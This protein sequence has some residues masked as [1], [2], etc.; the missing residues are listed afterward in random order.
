MKKNIEDL[1]NPL[2]EGCGLIQTDGTLCINEWQYE[3]VKVMYMQLQIIGQ[4]KQKM[5]QLTPDIKN[6]KFV[7]C[8]GTEHQSTFVEYRVVTHKCG[9]DENGKKIEWKACF[10]TDLTTP[11]PTPVLDPTPTPT[12]INQDA[13]KVDAVQT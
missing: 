9:P 6:F 3:C 7:D 1:C 2:R 11:T 12:P 13:P 8:D 5:D 10:D 4:L